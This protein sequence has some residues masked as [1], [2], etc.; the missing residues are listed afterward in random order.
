MFQ[1]AWRINGAQ[2]AVRVHWRGPSRKDSFRTDD[3]CT[4]ALETSE[5]HV[6]V[7][8][9]SHTVYMAIGVTL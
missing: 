4:G 8:T 1:M 2:G 5:E 3:Y 9:G 6:V 7:T